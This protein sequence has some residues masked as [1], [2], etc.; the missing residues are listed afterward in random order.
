MLIA[1]LQLCLGFFLV[2]LVGTYVFSPYGVA[3]L[4]SVFV[5]WLVKLAWEQRKDKKR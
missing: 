4:G 1:F 5:G 3:I 2:A